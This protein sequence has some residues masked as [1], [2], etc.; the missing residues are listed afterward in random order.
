[1]SPRKKLSLGITRLE[2]GFFAV[3]VIFGGLLATTKYLDLAIFV[4]D[5]MEQ[6]V[7][8]AVREGISAYREE[9]LKRG[10]TS[11]YPP[12]L[13]GAETGRSTPQ[14]LFFSKVLERGIAVEGWAKTNPY[15]YLTPSGTIFI[16]DPLTGNFDTHESATATDRVHSSQTLQSVAGDR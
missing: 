10:G 9:S 13:D 7:I 11:R 2:M 5:S 6:G 4:E 3:L 1:M 14:N 8:E 12:V 16:Y 15:Q